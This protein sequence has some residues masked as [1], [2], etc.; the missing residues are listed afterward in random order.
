MNYNYGNNKDKAQEKNKKSY[1]QIKTYQ[2][3]LN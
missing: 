3:Q 2:L 1:W